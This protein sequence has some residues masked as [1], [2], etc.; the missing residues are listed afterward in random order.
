MNFDLKITARVLL[1][2]DDS[3]TVVDHGTILVRD[4]VIREIGPADR[5][6]EAVASKTLHYPHGLVMPGLINTH[7]HAPMSLFRG[8]A[9]DLSLETW[10]HSYIF[11]AEAGFL[12]PDFAYWG[13]LLSTAEMALSGTTCFADGYFF[14]HH[15]A[16]A[17]EQS[18]LR[19]VLAQ[20][21]IDFPAP[22]VPDPAE[23][24]ATATRF[25]REW[26]GRSDLITPALFC[27]S[28]YTCSAETLRRGKKA[29][30]DLDA[31]FFAHLAETGGEVEQ[32]LQREGKTPTGFLDSLGVLDPQTVGVHC[33]WM[34]DEDMDIMA[35]RGAMVSHA[36]ESEMKL[37]SGV[38]PV[39]DLLRR[40]VT[41][42]LGTDGCASNN[43]QDM[44]QEM[45]VAAKL[46]KVSR[47]DPTALPAW[48]TVW[49][50]TRGGAAALGLGDLGGS[51]EK[52][53]RADIIVL[54]LR[55][56]HLLPLFDYYSHLVYAAKGSDVV[57][58][59]VNGKPIVEDGRFLAF[60]LEET[61]ERISRIA[62]NIA[63]T[64]RPKS[65]A[66]FS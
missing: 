38:P 63:R 59:L 21:V 56:P 23:N 64:L 32:V 51:L 42:S 37:A 66:A 3:R 6:G 11:P 20:G 5:Y 40:G 8:L 35:A 22:G 29:A 48:E 33:V 47:M 16:R 31:L 18:G 14:E 34:T 49:M 61:F 52:G 45:D 62:A 12:N 4:G 13:T 27:H 41:V 60:D 17:V 36:P 58:V 24:I 30:R 9:D 57:T 44:F 10:L 65:P 46:Q 15:V 39:P 54:D 1:T 25:I 26:R 28:T 7:T 53:K 19:A 55:K 2:L 43:D 50:A